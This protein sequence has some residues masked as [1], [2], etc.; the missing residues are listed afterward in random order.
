MAINNISN[1]EKYA[2]ELDKALVQKSVTGFL[3]DNVLKA[4]FVGAKTV[5][6]PRLSEH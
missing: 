2:A 5:I 3:A 6:I 1:A 4:Q